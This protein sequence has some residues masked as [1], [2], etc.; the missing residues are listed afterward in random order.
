MSTNL[1]AAI[2]I[3]SSDG[4]DP[5]LS[6]LITMKAVSFESSVRLTHGDQQANAKSLI[7]VMSLS[8]VCGDALNIHTAGEDAQLALNALIN[9][10]QH[11]RVNRI[12]NN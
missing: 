6:A 8:L 9:L 12:R 7:E 10:I 1:S 4:L 11:Y 2:T 3:T 5:E